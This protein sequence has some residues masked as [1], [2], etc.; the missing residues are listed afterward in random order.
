VSDRAA[1][2]NADCHAGLLDGGRLKQALLEQGEDFFSLVTE[3]CPHLFTGVPY[4]VSTSQMARMRAVTAAVEQVVKLPAWE[5]TIIPSMRDIAAAK[6]VFMGYD[7]HL[8]GE[9]AHLIEIN[10]N[11]GGAYLNALLLGSQR[12]VQMPGEAA[13]QE[14]LEQA[15]VDMFRNEWTL[16][17]GDVPLRTI[18]IID[19]HPQQQYLY[20]EF[21]LAQR[22]FERAGLEVLIADPS[23]LEANR[24]GVNCNG[25]RMDMIYNR[26]TDFSLTHHPALHAAWQ[27]RQVVLTPHPLAYALYANKRNLALLTDAQTLRAMG[28]AEDVVAALQAGIP[29]V[30]LVHGEDREYWWSERKHWFFKPAEGYGARGSYRGANITH[31]VFEEIMQD[32][33]VAQKLAWRRTRPSR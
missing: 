7:F 27:D 13:A 26:L 19:D 4:F 15:F 3:R 8:D 18:A 10:T 11:A 31:R 9:G 30:R 14:G 28:V 6:G 33:Y 24:D 32:G 29:E 21:L 17:R 1:V 2:L 25:V 22:L 5:K 12:E 23:E 20:P 16:E